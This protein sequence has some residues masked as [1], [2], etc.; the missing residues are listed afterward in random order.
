MKKKKAT[1]IEKAGI[2]IF[3]V[4]ILAAIFWAYVNITA[5]PVAKDSTTLL[6]K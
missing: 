5:T 2:V 4:F 3:A 6:S 1:L